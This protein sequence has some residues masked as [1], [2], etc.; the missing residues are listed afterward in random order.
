MSSLDPELLRFH[1]QLA[2]EIREDLSGVEEFERAAELHPYFKGYYAN[3][4]GDGLRPRRTRNGA[5]ARRRQVPAFVARLSAE[6]GELPTV[7]DVGCG[8]GSDSLLLSLLGCKVTGVDGSEAMAKVAAHRHEMWRPFLGEGVPRATFLFGRLEDL[9]ALVPGSFDGAFTSECLHHCEPVENALLA[10]RSLVR[11]GA[12]VLVLESNGR[13]L[14]NT[15]MLKRL[16]Q[17]GGKRRVLGIVDGRYRLYGNE[18][19][20]GPR[21]WRRLFRDCGFR[22]NRTTYSRHL[23]SELI[24]GSPR[25]DA[26]LCRMPGASFLTIHVAFDLVPEAS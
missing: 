12:R 24:G 25:L 20:R 18:N 1:E 3:W 21:M 4:S 17:Q 9:D 5:L 11:D 22:V 6:D 8:F 15:V 16:R 2:R 7:L 23:V 13:C 10:I 26:I 14:A 19:I